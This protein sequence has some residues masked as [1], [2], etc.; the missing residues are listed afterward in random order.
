MQQNKKSELN[1]RSVIYVRLSSLEY[2]KIKKESE[3]LG[4]SAPQLLRDSHFSKPP[5]KVLVSQNDLT[6][7]QKDLGRIG[8]NLN[9]VARRFNAGLLCGWSDKIDLILEQFETLTNQI[10]YGY[11]IHKS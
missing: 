1:A 7:L 9:Q 5:T 4:K 11:G 2:E 8:N 6:I 3:V 10:Y